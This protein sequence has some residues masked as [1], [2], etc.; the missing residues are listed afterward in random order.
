M[1]NPQGPSKITQKP[2]LRETLQFPKENFPL[3]E[4]NGKN[5]QIKFSPGKKLFLIKESSFLP[6]PLTLKES[7]NFS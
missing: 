2:S 5:P 6:K 3:G 4:N 7:P 1:G